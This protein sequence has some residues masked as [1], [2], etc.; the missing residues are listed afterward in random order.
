MSPRISHV[1]LRHV[2]LADAATCALTGLALTSLARPLAELFRLPAALLFY[3]GLALVPIA[4]LMAF[5]GTR[6]EPPA[7][8]VRLIIAGNAAWA[9]ASFALLVTDL[10][11]P[12]ALGAAFIALQA[13]VVVCLTVLE[14]KSSLSQGL[15]GSA[16]RRLA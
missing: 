10:V 1:P 7:P 4:A 15:L 2:L 5:V 3:A 8:W 9:L 13:L 12:N 11:A 14:V 6:A 16:D